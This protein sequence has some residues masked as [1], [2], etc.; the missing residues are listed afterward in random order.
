[1]SNTQSQSPKGFR[2]IKVRLGDL[3]L[4]PENLR[5][6]E[7]ADD[8]IDQLA[9]TLLAAG[10]LIPIIVRAGRKNEE[11]FMALDGR[12]RRMG[13][14][15]LKER[16]SITEDYV[17]DCLLAGDKQAQAAAVILP[18]SERAP[19]HI[20]DVITAIGKLRKARL[21]TGAIARA[22]GYAEIE[23]KRLEALANVD[24]TV[25]QALK[26]GRINLRQARLFARLPSHEK[27]AEIA[28]SALDGYFHDY[29]L[30]SLIDGDRVTIEDARLRLVGIDRYL[31]AGGRV[32]TDLF[33]EMPDALLDVELLQ[34]LW[35]G[36]VEPVVEH[37]KAQGFVVFVGPE[38][39]LQ[40]PDG[41][42]RLPYVY[43]RELSEDVALR[44]SDAR[45]ALDDLAERF[46]D[47][48][49]ASD[50][51]V[52]ALVAIFDAE[53][54]VAALP[55]RGAE[56][57]AVVVVPSPAK[58]VEVRFFSAPLPADPGDCVVDASNE[59]GL[60]DPGHYPTRDEINVPRTRV[61]LAGAG[62]VLHETRT[63]V[64]TRGLIRD[65]ADHPAAAQIVLLSQLFKAIALTGHGGPDASA[66][67]ITATV[68]R[69]TGSPDIP[70]LDG[71]VR[72]R[73]EARRQAYKASGLRPMGYV[74]SLDVAD[75]NS[76]MAELVAMTLNVREARTTQIRH[77]ARAEAIEIATLCQS[78]LAAHWTP[79]EAYLAVH[80][81][82][83]LLALLSEMGVDAGEAGDLKKDAL[84]KR[85]AEEAAHRV[86]APTV[87]SWKSPVET[88]QDDDEANAVRGD[89][90]FED[91]DPD[92][93][94]A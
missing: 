86:W 20:A 63:D 3:G 2:P 62:H 11:P 21:D 39:A 44:L 12:R 38:G 1:M 9:E 23:V 28:Q 8:G 87:L 66:A 82:K 22:L 79:D 7:P 30:R 55:L 74:Q 14:L 67:A 45:S 26:Q 58:G 6:E 60:T 47:L 69:R 57:S 18:N 10:V 92:E 64:A 29:Q 25:I 94:A 85:V 49:P 56:L 68:Y 83:Q 5:Y 59:V 80:S 37:F 81:K 89:E 84:V 53:R 40:A 31:A 61:D 24:P 93:L 78:D 75:R 91:D 54:A 73:L 33:A 50:E 51:G 4:A 52:A 35:R 32:E 90:D 65:L 76:L 88:V 72:S 70:S 43:G 41:F 42:D 48:D 19:V 13:L 15:R 34:T 71:E 16:G 36:R 17:I 46:A 77:A 27:Q